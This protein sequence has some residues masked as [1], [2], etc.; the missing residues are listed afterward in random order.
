MQSD[1]FKTFDRHLADI[2]NME[3]SNASKSYEKTVFSSKTRF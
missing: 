3:V 1:H 2:Q